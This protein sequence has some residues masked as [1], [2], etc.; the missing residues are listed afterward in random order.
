MAS[1]LSKPRARAPRLGPR[2]RA[3]PHCAQTL[4]PGA[5]RAPS[6][7]VQAARRAPG[8]RAPGARGGGKAACECRRRA[9][10]LRYEQ[11]P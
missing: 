7:L 9:R 1:A 11:P 8:L 6:P 10:A 3:R 2:G 5:A 4:R